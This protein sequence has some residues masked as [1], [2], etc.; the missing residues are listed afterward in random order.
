MISVFKSK[1]VCLLLSF[2]NSSGTEHS[3]ISFLFLRT[4]WLLL[5]Y[6]LSLSLLGARLAPPCQ[7]FLLLPGFLILLLT[8]D[9]WQ[10]NQVLSW[11]WSFC[12]IIP[13]ASHVLSTLGVLPSLYREKSIFKM[14]DITSFP[15]QVFHLRNTRSHEMLDDFNLSTSL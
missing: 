9:L 13:G 6:L 3:R 10:M 12:V 5:P 4:L 11:H 15:W 1:T 8:L 14:T 7:R 2:L